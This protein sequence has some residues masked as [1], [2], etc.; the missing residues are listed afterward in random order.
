MAKTEK[1]IGATRG[2]DRRPTINDIA[3]RAGLSKASVSRAL[4]GKQDVDP[5]T[6]QRVMTLATQMGYVPS[7]SARAL[8]NGRSNCLGLLVPTLTWPWILEVLRGVAAEIESS[9]YSLI[10]YTTAEGEESERAFMSQVVPAGAVDGLALVIPLGML[11]YVEHLAKGGLPVVVVD[12][13]GHYPDLPTVATTNVEGG[14]TATRHLIEEGRQRIAMLNGPHDFGCNRE[15]LEGYKSALKEAGLRFD[16]RHVIDSDFK[17]TGGASAM[18]ALL[19]ADPRLDA[20][21]VANDMMAFG[22]MRAL[23]SA[24]RLI[25]DDVAVVGFDDVPASAMTHPPL[26]TIR[27][28]LYEMGRTAASMVMAAVR[29]EPI[30]QRIELPTSLV[31]RESSGK[32]DRVK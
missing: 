13:R 14:R 3:K 15:R 4:N 32:P 22:A 31:I 21:F 18:S 6:R 27:Q 1:T 2:A 5:D 28:P 7:A 25:P 23:R 9:G 24:G 19:E 30:A 10:L 11:D 12:D 8:S 29:G 20:V 16:P 26:T 17:E